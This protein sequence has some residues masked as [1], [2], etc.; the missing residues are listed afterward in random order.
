M[1]LVHEQDVAGLQ[2]GQDRC[3]VALPL[4]RRAGDRADPNAE[5][6]PDDVREA[7][8]PQAGRPD[9][10]DVVERLSPAPSRLQRDRE[11]FLDARLADEVVERAR[12]QRAL[13][14]VLVGSDRGSQELRRGAQ[15]ALS[16]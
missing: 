7:R 12:T 9:E 4:E 2:R 10:Q 15:A 11:L 13:E 14:L 5:L 1:D 8:L 6:L 3:Q 16:A